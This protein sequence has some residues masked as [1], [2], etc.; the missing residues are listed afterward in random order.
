MV[1]A[2]VNEVLYDQDGVRATGIS[3]TPKS[4]SETVTAPTL[5]YKSPMVVIADGCFSKFR[6]QY[7]NKEVTVS[8]HFVG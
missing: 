8:S 4:A 3:C 7:L 6:K 1:E 5:T 2:T